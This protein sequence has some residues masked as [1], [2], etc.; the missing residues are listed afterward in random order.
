MKI[1]DTEQGTNA[2]ELLGLSCWNKDN[3]FIVGGMEAEI[4]LNTFYISYYG[5]L[6]MEYFT[7]CDT[8]FLFWLIAKVYQFKGGFG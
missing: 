7:I 2:S 5:V 8:Q 4:L 1:S 6:K 3:T